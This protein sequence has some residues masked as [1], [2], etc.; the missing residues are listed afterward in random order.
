M[1]ILITGGA[2]FI[3]SHLSD[4]L[5]KEG[6][7]VI[8]IDD[9]STGSMENIREAK[10]SARFEYHLD[11]IFNRR[12]LAELIDTADMVFHLAA[13]VG[14]RNIV[15]SPVRTIETNVRGAELVLEL[16]SKK[17]KR[18]LITSTS[19]VYGKSA[20]LPFREDDDLVLGPT[21]KAR[22]SYACSKMIDEFLALAYYHE[23]KL[24]ATI[25]RLFNTVGPRQTGRYGMVLPN[26]VQQAL[27]GN[28]VIVFGSGDQSR[29]FTHVTDVTQALLQCA[30]SA[31]TVGQ[32]FNV[33]TTEEVTMNGLAE[34]VISATQSAS[35]VRHISYEE[36][37]GSGFEDMDRRVPDISKAAKF[38]GYKP[39]YS[40]VDVVT[41]VIDYHR[42]KAKKSTQTGT[43]EEPLPGTIDLVPV[44]LLSSTDI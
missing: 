39:L 22:W 28:P 11:T 38:F 29:C 7:R 41:S 27:T 16:A 20:R 25:V 18:V 9:L 36:A 3:G 35:L 30:M 44:A 4:Y 8:V 21:S 19:E 43:A 12:I 2:G 37:Y 32:V 1:N 15:E 17:A 14:V 24:P 33:G 40:L 34:M 13:A 6:H 5:L 26:F 42:H 23:R 10:Q 31:D